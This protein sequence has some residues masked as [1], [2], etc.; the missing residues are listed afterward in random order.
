MGGMG[1][2]VCPWSS[3][4]RH[5]QAF[6]CPC[7]SKITCI[8][9]PGAKYADS[10]RATA[11]DCHRNAPQKHLRRPKPQDLDYLDRAQA[12]DN[13]DYGNPQD[14][15]PPSVGVFAKEITPVHHHQ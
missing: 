1:K 12:G 11:R 10:R 15:G 7:H 9:A 4:R 14:I 5:G 13:D 6:A 8:G 2:L 3:D